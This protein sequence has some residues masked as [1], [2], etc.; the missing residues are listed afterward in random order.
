[1]G[2]QQLDEQDDVTCVASTGLSNVERAMKGKRKEDR[3]LQGGK[4][5]I[6]VGGEY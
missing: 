3:R 5:N 4:I 2:F 1:M 6:R